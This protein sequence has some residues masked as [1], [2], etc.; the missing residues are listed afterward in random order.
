[1]VSVAKSV[2]NC[3]IYYGLLEFIPACCGLSPKDTCIGYLKQKMLIKPIK[4][5]LSTKKPPENRGFNDGGQ[6]QT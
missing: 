4:M 5:G 6:S 3:K 1:M 2:A